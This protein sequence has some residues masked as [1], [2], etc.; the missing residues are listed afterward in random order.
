MAMSSVV[1]DT[2]VIAWWLLD[3]DRLTPAARHAI[4]DAAEIHV[5]VASLYEVEFKRRLET[6]RGQR[7]IL[8]DLPSDLANHLTTLD[9]V[10]LDITPGVAW[11]A[12]R[13]LM[14]HGDPWDRIILAHAI[15]LNAPLVSSDARLRQAEDARVI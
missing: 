15:E 12:A 11:T 9:L 13:L 2:Q 3:L 8:H 1:S 6:K 5:S 4:A 14:D 7:S 10:L